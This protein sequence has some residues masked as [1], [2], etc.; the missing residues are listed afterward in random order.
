M[1]TEK[2][3][4]NY[5]YS[6]RDFDFKQACSKA[7]IEPTKRQAS[8]YRRGKGKAIKFVSCNTITV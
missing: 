8:K 7:G 4:T 5:E 6:T 2:R 1:T 3:I